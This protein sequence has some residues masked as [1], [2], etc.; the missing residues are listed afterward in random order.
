MKLGELR[1]LLMPFSD[2]LDVKLFGSGGLE[3][4]EK[5]SGIWQTTE[6]ATAE[7]FIEAVMPPDEAEVGVD[8]G[9]C[10]DD[11]GP[12]EPF[13]GGPIEFEDDP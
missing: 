11:D 13:P 7:L 4:I 8:E 9:K 3:E 1:A 12:A 6:G 2:D 10:E 5:V